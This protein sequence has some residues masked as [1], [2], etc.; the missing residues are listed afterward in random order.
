MTNLI[1]Y[2]NK[3]YN[4]ETASSFELA[5]T[6]WFIRWASDRLRF[7]NS[8]MF[9]FVNKHVVVSFDK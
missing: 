1:K 2:Y 3:Y 7:D 9:D 5:K 8:E 4:L 6:H